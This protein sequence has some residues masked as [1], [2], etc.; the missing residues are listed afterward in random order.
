MDHFAYQNGAMLAE[1]VPVAE[2]AARVGTPFY[3]YSTATIE[4][5]YT[6]FAQ[7][8]QDTDALIAF[9][10][11]SNSNQ[12]VIRTLARLG[13][14]ADV[15]SEGE[16][17]RA[18]DAGVDSKKIVFSG[19]GKTKAELSFALSAGIYQFNVESEAEL[20]TLND[21]AQS[22]GKLAPIAVRVTPDVDGKTHAK[23]TTGTK[24]SKFGIDWQDAREFYKIAAG[25]PG[26]E[27]KGISTHIGSQITDLKPFKQAFGRIVELVKLLRADGHTIDRLDL[28]GGLGVPYGVEDPANPAEYAAMVKDLTRHL[29]CRLMFEPGRLIVA[30]AGILVTS[31]IALK[32][33]PAREFLIVDAAMNDLIRPSFYDAYHE[34]VAVKLPATQERRS[35]DVVGP[36]CE[37]GDVFA[38]DRVLPVFAPGDLVAFRTAGAYGAVMSG[39]YNSRLLIPEI[40]VKGNQFSVIRRRQTYD[41]LIG[42]DAMPAWL[43]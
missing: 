9:A 17:R 40:L 41:E 35:F 3:C 29:N 23:I 4:R 16:I 2:I 25:L 10:L 33:T 38:R 12:A 39:T 8:F 32:K 20:R 26:I 24:V 1:N 19:M 13:A 21:V 34:I 27:V 15:V 11:K 31:V 37:T 14:G 28:G 7:A 42:M 30:N 22:M 5:H 36:V 6:V 43:R 18:L